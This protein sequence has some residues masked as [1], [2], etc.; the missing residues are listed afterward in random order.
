MSLHLLS[1]FCTI[2]YRKV[3]FCPMFD[4]SSS[5]FEAIDE[6]QLKNVFFFFFFFISFCLLGYYRSLY[7]LVN[8]KLP[9]SLE[10]SDA[11]SIPL[12]QT[13]LEHTL[14]PLHFTYSSCPPDTRY[15]LTQVHTG[16]KSNYFK[17]FTAF[18]T[19]YALES[20]RCKLLEECLCVGVCVVH[21]SHPV[22]GCPLTP[23]CRPLALSFQRTNEQ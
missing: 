16:K 6:F 17:L 18:Y 15:T 4:L 12:A 20:I 9:S 10:Y 23:Y 7:V 13:L 8:H 11:P 19:V 3:Q 5:Y 1:K 2:W 22:E 14:K 21:R